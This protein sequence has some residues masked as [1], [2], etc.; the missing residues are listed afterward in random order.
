MVLTKKDLDEAVELL[1]ERFTGL[2]DENFTAVVLRVGALE[3]SIENNKLV[4][5]KQGDEIIDLKRANDEL[6]S[7]IED[8]NQKLE[9]LVSANINF[10]T[11]NI[12]KQVHEIE[13]RLED[14][15]NRQLRQTL[16][17]RGVKEQ[18]DEDWDDTKE[19]VAELISN[20]TKMSFNT[21]EKMINRVHRGRRNQNR[22]Q[23]RPIYMALH[24]WQDCENIVEVFRNLNIKKR[25]SI[26]VSYMYGPK[27]S[28]RRNAAL[29]KRKQLKEEGVIASG[30]IQF[31]AKLMIKRVGASRDEPYELIEDFSNLKVELKARDSRSVNTDY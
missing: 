12:A 30:Y 15:T 16:I 5:D 28:I 1:T 19:I 25:S 7:K 22:N 31:P 24:K 23:P 17:F 29:L 14:R 13:E 3:T 20:N 2:L 9:A 27:T 18:Q 11:S 8:L 26:Q 10:D 4:I 6:S 21:A